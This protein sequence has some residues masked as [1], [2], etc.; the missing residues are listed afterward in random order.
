[1]A[2]IVNAG[3]GNWNYTNNTGGNVRVIIAFFYNGTTS[4]SGIT[5]TIANVN[6]ASYTNGTNSSFTGFGKHVTWRSTNSSNGYQ[7]SGVV[8]NAGD[9][10]VDEFYL[11]DG[12]SASVT[13]TSGSPKGYNILIVPEE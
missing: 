3:P 11:A 5:Q 12:Q 9:G 1:M 4:T 10:F 2:S 7:V 6:V 13:A 8:G